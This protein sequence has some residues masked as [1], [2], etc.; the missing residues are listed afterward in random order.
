MLQ[1]ALK[2]PSLYSDG[3]AYLPSVDGAQC[4]STTAWNCV[5]DVVSVSLRSLLFSSNLHVVDSIILCCTR[6]CLSE[7][8]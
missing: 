2:V 6:S 8:A 3:C 4:V 7:E 5:C 1:L